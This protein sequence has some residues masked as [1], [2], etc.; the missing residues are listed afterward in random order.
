MSAAAHSLA[1]C[2]ALLTH[3]I[4]STPAS[5][6]TDPHLPTV[7]DVERVRADFPILGLQVGNKPLVYLDNAASSQMP[8]PVMQRLH[9]YQ[10]FEHANIHRAVHYLSAVSYTHLDVYKRQCFWRFNTPLKFRVWVI[11]SFYAWPTTPCKARAAKKSL[12]RWSLTTWCA[13][14]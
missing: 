3:P 9:H 12:T 6:T 10:T 2:E 5:T 7:L 4:A 11:A 1:V 13:K 8:T 14:K